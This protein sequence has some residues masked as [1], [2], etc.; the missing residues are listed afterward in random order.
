MSIAVQR[1]QGVARRPCVWQCL[2]MTILDRRAALSGA[3]AAAVAHGSIKVVDADDKPKFKRV[4]PIQFI[5][6]L[7]EADASFGTGADT[8]GLWR[9]DPGPR[10]VWLSKFKQLESRGGKAPAGWI[11]DQNQ[12]W[13]E[14]HG[15]IM[16]KPEVLPAR[17]FVREGENVRVIAR[18]KR[19]VVTG[20]REVTSV[21]TVHD[22]GRWELS[23]GTLYDVTHLPCR[24]AIYTPLAESGSCTPTGADRSVFPVRPGA[25]MPQVQGCAKQ[26]W[27]VLFVVGVEA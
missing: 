10:G 1:T 9:E 25:L 23:K 13:L 14:E 3:V 2:A 15:L 26:D 11:F 7:G 12:W 19:Y 8:W 18:Q 21:L 22:D 6:A 27:A 4:S 5:A 20:D 24:S 17:K 16:E